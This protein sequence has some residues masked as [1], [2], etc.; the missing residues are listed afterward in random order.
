MKSLQ[1][2]FRFRCPQSKYSA[3]ADRMCRQ[4]ARA[5]ESYPLLALGIVCVL[6]EA[7]GAHQEFVAGE[8]FEIGFW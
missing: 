2:A 3:V 5:R 7:E 6:E 8:I 1:T 4:A